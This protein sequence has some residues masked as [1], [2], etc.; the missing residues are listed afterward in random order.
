MTY[1]PR[2]A[3]RLL[4]ALLLAWV[5]VPVLAAGYTLGN[6]EIHFSVPDNWLMIMEQM[7]GEPQ[8]IAFQ[9]PDASPS[10]KQVL[11]RVTVTMRQVTD[12]AKFRSWVKI[13]VRKSHRL[14]GYQANGKHYSHRFVYH[15]LENGVRMQYLELYYFKNGYAVQLRCLRPQH[16][17]SGET[18]QNTFD[19]G[20]QQIARSFNS[21][22]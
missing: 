11:S 21:P 15:A 3:T 13:Q 17:Q 2:L 10:G 19:R 7:Q 18:W 9:V 20:C 22:Q 14:P 8:F 16:D 12:I 4:Y 1:H 5:S 6:G